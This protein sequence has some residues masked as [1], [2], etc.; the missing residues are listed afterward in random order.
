LPPQLGL[1]GQ[2]FLQQARAQFGPPL[3]I[4]FNARIASRPKLALKPI[5]QAVDL[6]SLA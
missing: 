3:Y 4:I 6:F 5:G 1:Q 2:K